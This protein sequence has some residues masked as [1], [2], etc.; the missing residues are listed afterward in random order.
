VTVAPTIPVTTLEDVDCLIVLRARLGLPQ[1]R[2]EYPCAYC[3]HDSRKQ[4]GVPLDCGA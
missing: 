4:C 3:P 2:C 1:V